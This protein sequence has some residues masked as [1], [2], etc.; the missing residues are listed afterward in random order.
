[1]SQFNNFIFYGQLIK[2]MS[3]STVQMNS[4]FHASILIPRSTTLE[5]L[6][7]QWFSR[8]GTT[9]HTRKRTLNHCEYP[10]WWRKQS[11]LYTS[12]ASS[13]SMNQ[14]NSFH[15]QTKKILYDKTFSHGNITN[16]DSFFKHVKDKRWYVKSKEFEPVNRLCFLPTSTIYAI[17]SL[18]SNTTYLYDRKL[19]VSKYHYFYSLASF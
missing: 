5:L 3:T 12:R 15:L 18:K 10:P 6:W 2:T 13:T 7:Y 19:A 17:N 8:E 1:M 16:A 11:Y 4:H 9:H 14:E